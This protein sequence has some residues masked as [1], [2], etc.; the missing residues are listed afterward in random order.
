M[1]RSGDFL[2]RIVTKLSALEKQ[3]WGDITI[4]LPGRRAGRKLQEAL[5]QEAGPGHW[6]PHITTLGEWSAEQLGLTVPSK[7]EL[8]VELQHVAEGMRLH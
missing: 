1:I 3:A 2:D 4:L 8:L 7:M 6:L 5:V